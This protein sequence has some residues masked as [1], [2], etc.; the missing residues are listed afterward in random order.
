MIPENSAP[1]YDEMAERALLGAII[2]YPEALEEV[3][4]IL[5]PQHFY[6]HRNEVIY[7]TCLEL[8]LHQRPIDNVTLSAEL[9]NQQ[10]L[11]MIGGRSYVVQL[12]QDAY[13]WRN[14]VH[15]AEIVSSTFRKRQIITIAQ[16]T[17][18][19][20]MTNGISASE[21]LDETLAKF[22]ALGNSSGTSAEK[23]GEG[24]VE[25]YLNVIKNPQLI[26]RLTWPWPPLEQILHGLRPGEMT[27]IGGR[28]GSGKTAIAMNLALKLAME[29]K[30]AV[31]IFSLEMTKTQLI[32]RM[33]A[34]LAEV[35]SSLLQDAKISAMEWQ[36][37]LEV[38][39]P[40]SEAPIY[41]DGNSALTE[42]EFITQSRKMKYQNNIECV[43]L[44]Y[45]QLLKSSGKPGNREQEVSSFA[46]TAKRIA[47]ELDIAVI[48]LSSLNR[49]PE[50]REDHRPIISDFRESGGI[51]NEADVVLGLYR[52]YYYNPSG[53]PNAAEVIVLKHRNGPVGTAHLKFEKKYTY[54]WSET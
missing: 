53:N 42:V 28:P 31:G 4:H 33:L 39:I 40:L 34:Q 54:F 45:L 13:E 9:E 50:F 37:I 10:S 6:F 24:A 17:V 26:K 44:D 47:R 19:R 51:E 2:R 3:A 38:S 16:E 1:P 43:I 36:K 14:A 48:V 49:G 25:S 32:N 12:M 30:K 52:D 15:Y 23:L 21:Y 8:F 11:N 46:Q 35:D 20:G 41:V 18:T 29:Q 22:F 7:A 5:R 27:T